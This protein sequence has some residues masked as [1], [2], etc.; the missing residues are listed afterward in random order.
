MLAK[1]HLV[2]FPAA[3]VVPVTRAWAEGHH[4]LAA[5]PTVVRMLT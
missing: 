2:R 4:S 1:M 5:V 3:D